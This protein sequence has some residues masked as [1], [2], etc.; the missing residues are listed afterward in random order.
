MRHLRDLEPVHPD[1]LRS[2]APRFDQRG[3]SNT[4]MAVVLAP[5][6]LLGVGLVVDGGGKLNAVRE[7]DAAAQE[8]ARAGADAGAVSLV[9]GGV[10]SK[11]AAK[12]AASAYLADAGVT[13]TV[14]VE[15]RTVTVTATKEYRTMLVSLI[16]INRLDGTATATAEV[17]AN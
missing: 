16:S 2:G 13:G 1:G 7:A 17:L 3:A 11:D 9:G 8:A 5:A 4:L 10:V 6:L 12:R 15:G 14:S